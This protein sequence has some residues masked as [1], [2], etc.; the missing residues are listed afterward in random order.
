MAPKYA[1]PRQ[2][3]PDDPDKDPWTSTQV[4]RAYGR[5][6]GVAALKGVE[7]ATKERWMAVKGLVAA[8][9]V[10]DTNNVDRQRYRVVDRRCECENC[11]GEGPVSASGCLG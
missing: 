6:V 2:S 4:S 10:T 7:P 1:R 9:V 5:H 8:E 3:I 11:K